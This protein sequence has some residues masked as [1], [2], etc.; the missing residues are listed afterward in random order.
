LAPEPGTEITSV[1]SAGDVN[2]D[3]LGDY[4]ISAL[5]TGAELPGR[6]YVIFGVD[7]NE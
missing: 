6:V 1:Q 4:L 3:G 5:E 7:R 2:G